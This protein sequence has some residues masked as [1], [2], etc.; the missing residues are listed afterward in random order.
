MTQIL[1]KDE[2]MQ[3]LQNIADNQI[4]HLE[5]KMKEAAE[6]VA[7]EARKNTIPSNSPYEDMVFPTKMAAYARQTGRLA[8]K[9]V[10]M[11]K[12][13]SVFV[14]AEGAYSGAPYSISN[15]GMAHMHDTIY[16][17]VDTDQA[18][19][20]GFVGT[21][22]DYSIWVH[23][24]TSRMFARPFLTDAIAAK[25]KA[26]IRILSEAVQENLQEQAS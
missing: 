9:R 20:H 19:V 6:I 17:E 11:T 21:P 22:K 10:K 16:A 13:P 12:R 26:V 23:E 8:W 25:E 5:E 14:A 18:G 15:E 7:G 3:K 2:L 1:T 4:K 24:G